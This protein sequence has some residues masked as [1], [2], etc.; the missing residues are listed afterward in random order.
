MSCCQ[1]KKHQIIVLIAL[2]PFEL[3]W[4]FSQYVKEAI[5]AKTLPDPVNMIK[6]GNQ[7]FRKQDSLT[8]SSIS[9]SYYDTHPY[10]FYLENSQFIAN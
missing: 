2:F 3:F 8:I 10:D 9:V 7:F 6:N 4:L 1:F 5:E